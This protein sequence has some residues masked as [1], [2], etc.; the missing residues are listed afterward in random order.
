MSGRP[1][2]SGDGEPPLRPSAGPGRWPSGP[3]LP[4][5]AIHSSWRGTDTDRS[6][7]YPPAPGQLGGAEPRMSG[8]RA[9]PTLS[10]INAIS[11]ATRPL[12]QSAAARTARLYPSLIAMTIS[13]PRCISTTVWETAPPSNTREAPWVRL[14]RPDVTAASW[15]TRSGGKPCEYAIGRPSDETTM[16]CATEGTRSTKL[17]TS[18]LRSCAGRVS[19]LTGSPS[20]DNGWAHRSNRASAPPLTLLSEFA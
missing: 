12:S 16:A 9:L 8:V 2:S 4:P 19:G 18:Q 11:Y 5:S 15:S 20:C 10:T 3:D 6:C 1:K 17:V 7:H 14:V 13:R